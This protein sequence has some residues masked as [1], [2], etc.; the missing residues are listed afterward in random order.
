MIATRVPLSDR[1]ENFARV[2][3]LFELMLHLDSITI[4]AV[5]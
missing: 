3:F 2:I 1:I 4:L 5:A